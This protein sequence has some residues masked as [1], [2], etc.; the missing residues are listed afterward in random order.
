ML[1]YSEKLWRVHADFPYITVCIN[2]LELH[3]HLLTQIV[4]PGTCI[5]TMDGLEAVYTIKEEI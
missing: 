3:K 5:I 2:I 4:A 1:D